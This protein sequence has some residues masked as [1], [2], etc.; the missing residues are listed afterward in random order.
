MSAE[1]APQVGPRPAKVLAAGT[2]AA[3]LLAALSLLA[4]DQTTSVDANNWLIWARQAATGHSVDPAW[5]QTSFKPLPVIVALPFSTVSQ[6]AGNLAWLWLVRFGLL[7]CPT[8]LFLLVSPRFGRAAGAVAAILPF[9]LPAW[10]GFAIDGA[11]EPVVAALLLTAAVMAA[12]QRPA[13][14]TAALAAS[15]LLRPE[16]AGLL[17]AWLAW[18]WRRE[19]TGAAAAHLLPAAAAIA[20][21]WFAL[22]SALGIGSAQASATA[23]SR[24]FVP[25]SRDGLLAILPTTV[26]VLVA[27]G[28]WGLWRRRDPIVI[29][30]TAG[31]AL[32]TAEVALLAS[33]GFPGVDRYLYPAAVA[34]CA[35]AGAG[36]S[37]LAGLLPSARPR[38][39]ASLGLIALASTLAAIEIPLARDNVDQRRAKAASA[40]RAVDA[41]TQ[42]G[43]MR[44]WAGCRPF[45]ANL[46]QSVIIARMLGQPLSSFV[47]ARRAP[48]IAFVETDAAS[49]A[50]GPTVTGGRRPVI[51]GASRPDWAIVLFPG[52]EGC[53]R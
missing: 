22:P 35:T 1:A 23:Q 14:V 5:A 36:A 34:L 12:L 53:G 8:L 25:N 11:S 50:N 29:C 41:F 6:F 16:A 15:T 49:N 4:L 39:A 17:V 31:A 10:V 37:T 18:L 33:L 32:W 27:A 3:A 30:V 38:I 24:L 43:G 9:A 40:E 52:G 48:A 7:L 2:A 20:L 42:S 26:W 13:A 45:A 44:R 47:S 46:G 19:G 51:V 21:G 28:A